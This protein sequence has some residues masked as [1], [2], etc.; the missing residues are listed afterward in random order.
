MKKKDLD[1]L[2]IVSLKDDP[3]NSEQ[4]SEELSR[5]Q[6][7]KATIRRALNSYGYGGKFIMEDGHPCWIL[8]P[9]QPWRRG[10][11]KIS[12]EVLVEEDE[13]SLPANESPLDD[14]RSL[15]DS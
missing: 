12:I 14:I 1:D 3:N 9:M 4:P 6:D 7:M 15:G 10:K 11:I 13:Q 8:E 5:W 2:T